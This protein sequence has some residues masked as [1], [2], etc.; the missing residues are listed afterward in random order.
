MTQ[1]TPSRARDN[2]FHSNGRAQATSFH[3]TSCFCLRNRNDLLW[4][5]WVEYLR[6]SIAQYVYVVCTLFNE[7]L[8]KLPPTE[9]M[10]TVNRTTV[11]WWLLVSFLN[12]CYS[13]PTC[14]NCYKIIV[15]GLGFG[16]DVYRLST[17]LCPKSTVSWW[18]S[19][20]IIDWYIHD[21][22]SRR[23]LHRTRNYIDSPIQ[24]IVWN[25]CSPL[26]SLAGWGVVSIAQ[27][28]T[29]S[30]QKCESRL[31]YLSNVVG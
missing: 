13:L 30:T 10:I 1:S 9:P 24:A 18:D 3:S 2:V 27:R 7:M 25:Q 19:K 11:D 16:L 20:W 28:A 5:E 21:I 29:R 23:M 22:K 6:G 4:S 26:R 8:C 17:I 15:S 12:A 31:R 14:K